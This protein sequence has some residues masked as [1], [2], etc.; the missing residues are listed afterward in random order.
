MSKMIEVFVSCLRKYFSH[1][2]VST[3]IVLLNFWEWDICPSS[4]RHWGDFGSKKHRHKTKQA[5]IRPKIHFVSIGF[6]SFDLLIME[7]RVQSE[8]FR[9]TAK[10]SNAF[11]HKWYPVR[12]L[13]R[14]CVQLWYW[15]KNGVFHLSSRREKSVMPLQPEQVQ[16]RLWNASSKFPTFQNSLFSCL[17]SCPIRGWGYRSGIRLFEFHLVNC[18]NRSKVAIPYPL[19][20][21]EHLSNFFAIR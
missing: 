14:H 7:I 20:L 11:V 13:H 5:I 18:F 15:R 2:Y 4:N 17:W 1:V 9:C 6:Y 21:Y 8:I 10:Q 19:M 3:S 16:E 12:I